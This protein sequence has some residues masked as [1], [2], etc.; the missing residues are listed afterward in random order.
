MPARRSAISTAP[1]T[2]SWYYGLTNMGINQ[3]TAILNN[4][5]H[6]FTGWQ[7]QN[8]QLR[9]V[10]D[11]RHALFPRAGHAPMGQ[12]PFSLLDSVSLTGAFVVSTAPDPAT[13]QMMIIGFGIVGG[14]LRVRRRRA[15]SIAIA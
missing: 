4:V 15:S 6:G 10:A 9:R 11:Q 1:T 5:N 7:T 2:D 3:Q 14:S 13:W 12:P 8:L